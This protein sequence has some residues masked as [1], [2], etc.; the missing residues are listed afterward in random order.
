MKFFSNFNRNKDNDTV[1]FAALM[2]FE[3][4]LRL[5]KLQLLLSLTSQHLDT[6]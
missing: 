6:C 2:S 1:Q 3:L 4:W 5:V